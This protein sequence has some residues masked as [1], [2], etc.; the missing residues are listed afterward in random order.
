V[1][2]SSLIGTYE[3]GAVVSS[4]L[5]VFDPDFLRTIRR[6]VR[7][8]VGSPAPPDTVVAHLEQAFVLPEKL[9]GAII[10]VL[11][12]LEPPE[13]NIYAEGVSLENG[14]SRAGDPITVTVIAKDNDEV[15]FLS[16]EVDQGAGFKA[17]SLSANGIYT[18]T[19]LVDALIT[20]RVT[21]RDASGN[22]GF[23]ETSMRTVS[24]DPGEPLIPGPLSG[25][26]PVRMDPPSAP[27]SDP[28]EPSGEAPELTGGDEISFDGDIVLYFSE[29]LDT[30]TINKDSVQ[31]KDPED[32]AVDVD[33]PLPEANGTVIRIVPKRYL[34]LGACYTIHLSA[35][36]MDLEGKNI[37]EEN[38][39]FKVPQPLQLAWIG[40]K[41]TRDIV[42]AGDTLVVANHPDGMG[43]TDFG[44]IHAY[45]TKD[46]EGRVLSKPILLSSKQVNGRPVSLAEDCGLVFVGN[47]YLGS[48]ASRELVFNFSF[49]SSANDFSQS[50]NPDTT[51][52]AFP[53]P[54]LLEPSFLDLLGIP[55]PLFLGL[56]NPYVVS[57]GFTSIPVNFPF[58]SNLGVYDISDP[59]NMKHVGNSLINY[60]SKEL[61]AFV[62]NPNASVYRVEVTDQGVAVLNFLDN[63][64]IFTS[65]VYPQSLGVV[66]RIHSPG[67]FAG[68]CEN[69]YNDLGY[70]VPCVQDVNWPPSY[71]FPPNPKDCLRTSCLSTDEFLDAAFFNGFAVILVKGGIR[72][73]STK[74]EVL[75]VRVNPDRTLSF[76]P[77][78]GSFLGRLGGV[79]DFEWWDSKGVRHETN[80]V[81]V[82]GQTDNRL[83]IFDMND[84]KNPRNLSELENSYGNMSFDSCLGLAYIRGRNGEFHIVDFNDPENPRELNNP[85]GGEAFRVAGLG[86]GVS[87][88]GNTNSD[89]VIY[90]SNRPGFA[91]VQM[92]RC[93]KIGNDCGSDVES[94]D[95]T[96]M[97]VNPKPFSRATCEKCPGV[98]DIE[99]EFDDED[100]ILGIS[101]PPDLNNPDSTDDYR[102]S[103]KLSLSLADSYSGS[104]PVKATLTQSGVGKVAFRNSSS[105]K[106]METI[107]VELER[108]NVNEIEVFG[109]NP[110]RARDDTSMQV[111]IKGSACDSCNRVWLTVVGVDLDV[112]SDNNLKI[113]EKEDEY[114]E[115]P[116]GF[117][118]WVNEGR[119][120]W[121]KDSKSTQ[122]SKIRNL[123]NFS[124]VKMTISTIEAISGKDTTLWLPEGYKIYL[125][126]QKA[127]DSEGSPEIRIVKKAG[128]DLEYLSDEDTAK[129]QVE[130]VTNK[131]VG[132]VS[133]ID[134][135]MLLD[136]TYFDSNSEEFLFDVGGE[137]EAILRLILKAPDG[138]TIISQDEVL[139]TLKKLRQMYT[140][141]YAR[142]VP[143]GSDVAPTKVYWPVE[144]EGFSG[145]SEL[146]R[147]S[148]LVFV[149]G[150]NVTE[151]A[152]YKTFDDVFRRFYW[153]G[154]TN[155]KWEIDDN[156]PDGI[157][158][159]GTDFIGLTW[160]G[161]Q[162]G[163]GPKRELYY[164]AN[165]F[166]AFEASK[167]V[168]VFL[169][170]MSVTKK[171]DVMAHSLG[172]M[173]ISNA[174]KKV[175]DIGIKKYVLH[176]AAVTANA[177]DVNGVIPHYLLVKNADEWG[178]PDDYHWI[179]PFN[180]FLEISWPEPRWTQNKYLDNGIGDPWGDYFSVVP[181]RVTMINTFSEADPVLGFKNLE[182]N[183]WM[184]NQEINRPDI[185]VDW[186]GPWGMFDRWNELPDSLPDSYGS[187]DRRE[188]AELSYYF[189]AVAQPAG[190]TKI[191]RASDNIDGRPMGIDSHSAFKENAFYDVWEFWETVAKKLNPEEGN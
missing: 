40:L 190:V 188:W 158:E 30:N 19:P 182:I 106:D 71:V 141:A 47:H 166:N 132:S 103:L 10:D 50:Y 86:S 120:V 26:A 41:N 90:L 105:S 45:Q 133:S 177:Y 12:D 52:G 57:I 23:A 111:S 25:R 64:E 80:L 129:E 164:N 169:K 75:D 65:D 82:A 135:P 63:I 139:I 28:E 187:D 8:A 176:Q 48:L 170:E 21:A 51:I 91:I 163:F 59:K 125:E 184:K 94:S 69:V 183:A 99:M 14:F 140:M 153:T 4:R 189:G 7:G 138:E 174:I 1:A 77:M 68:R 16:L 95:C 93:A 159:K 168:G 53:L 24:A 2:D 73:F 15:A 117:E 123:E 127:G 70:S 137:G 39:P 148:V 62:W 171:V 152:A 33:E 60:H 22:S 142:P 112:D 76:F 144:T 154:L 124:T 180:S 97:M 191:Y 161:N 167:P 108:G 98:L 150:Y 79:P 147:D 172:N 151:N 134:E 49:F 61:P 34:R 20:F 18:M 107:E 37:K 131:A 185:V 38:I 104:S 115:E 113:E 116:P 32:Q 66:E 92:K 175:D 67:Q 43:M 114:E 110:S 145:N 55:N 126:M 96:S 165:V 72:V 9:P 143:I 130:L 85:G 155:P 84:P 29:P 42:L 136:L 13:V 81:F 162:Y 31:L 173:V 119:S 54:P 121:G 122:E 157:K 83:T 109:K 179:A 128:K 156:E 181:N 78:P 6:D 5:D 89:G 88:D 178:Y 87:P 58:P 74:E 56:L 118:F 11:G 27:P 186:D 160:Y 100:R 101:S 146:K 44:E 102:H 46:E 149:H 35:S 17:V 3:V 36:I